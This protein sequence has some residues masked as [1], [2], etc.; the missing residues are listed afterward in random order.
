MSRA[1]PQLR[2]DTAYAVLEP[3]KLFIFG[4]RLTYIN[5]IELIAVQGMLIQRLEMCPTMPLFTISPVFISVLKYVDYIILSFEHIWSW[6]NKVI[7][8]WSSLVK[9]IREYH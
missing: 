3:G 7:F 2:S 8:A 4:G 9:N 1:A 6:Q 5:K